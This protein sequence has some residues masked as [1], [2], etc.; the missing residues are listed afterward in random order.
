MKITVGIP[1]KNR[2]NCLI[3][4]LVS[5][6]L[7]TKK[8]HEVIIV[9]DSDN[10]LDLRN[11]PN[12]SYVF[13]LF[14]D[15]K[16]SWKVIYGQK[17]GQHYSHQTIQEMATGDFVFRVD[18]DCIV[19]A[20]VLEKLS[21]LMTDDVGAVAPLVITPRATPCPPN[22]QNS[23]ENIFAPN[24]Q[25]FYWKGIKEVD[26]LYSCFLYRK[27]I[28]RYE[29]S[30][31]NK[32]HREETIFS[33]SLKREGYK[34]L[35]NSDAVVHHFRSESG[36]IRSDKNVSDF[37]HDEKIFRGYLQLWGVEKTEK[38]VVLDNGIGDHYSF[39]HILPELKQ[40][41]PKIVIAVCFPEIFFDVKDVHLVSIQQAKDTYG[42]I[43][44]FNI[45]GKMDEWKWT[46]S[47][48]DAFKKMY[49]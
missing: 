7:Q 25:W 22:A 9:D 12:Y 43:G 31:S 47:L 4:T 38:V 45:Y 24:V 5:I 14:D 46:G 33:H 34:L 11:I 40:K 1:T 27:N 39:L 2:H 20:D 10:P 42:D 18:D 28:I 36:G 41:Y 6:A 30:L 3:Q 37:E 32:A 49:L 48:V 26:H 19:N 15:Y 44:Q 8:P 21:E 23:I 13:K 17:K 16:I 29:L 35:V